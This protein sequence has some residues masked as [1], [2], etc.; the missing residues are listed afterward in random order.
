MK[1]TLILIIGLIIF[2][3][4]CVE[5]NPDP[6]AKTAKARKERAEKAKTDLNNIT[7]T[8]NGL[9]CL[10]SALDENLT[11]NSVEA[12]ADGWIITLFNGATATIKNAFVGDIPSI[13]IT[14][15]EG[16]LVWTVNGT[17]IKGKDGN[18]VNVAASIPEFKFENDTWKY[19]VAGG[20][21]TECGSAVSKGVTVAEDDDCVTVTVGDTFIKIDKTIYGVVVL[22]DPLPIE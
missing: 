20:A 15:V 12:I 13:G 8:V 9:S 14:K 5:V 16:K 17:V 18:P 6:D 21:W 11:V 3:V 10:V 7:V 22:V 19:R 4:G 1:K 2:T